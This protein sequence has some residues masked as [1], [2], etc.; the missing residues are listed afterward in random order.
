MTE[1]DD[2]EELVLFSVP[3]NGATVE[4]LMRL[5]D[6]CHADPRKIAASLLRD[7]LAEDAEA[8]F[9]EDVVPPSTARH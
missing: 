1:L 5:A 4:R 2:E 7:I 6:I 3:L 9:F 8:H